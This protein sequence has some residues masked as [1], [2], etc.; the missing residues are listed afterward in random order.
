M[1]RNAVWDVTPCNLTEKFTNSM[2]QKY[3][4]PESHRAG[5]EI[6]FHLQ[7]LRIH[8]DIYKIP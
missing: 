1:N 3:S 6:P 2:K 4:E 5:Y 7:N 8:Y